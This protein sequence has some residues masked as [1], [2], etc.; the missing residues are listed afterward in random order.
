[1]DPSDDSSKR[2]P[3]SGMSDYGIELPDL[4]RNDLSD[5]SAVM[6]PTNA[7]DDESFRFDVAAGSSLRSD[8]NLNPDSPTNV[9]SQQNPGTSNGSWLTRFLRGEVGFSH[10]SKQNLS[11]D[12][13][14]SGGVSQAS[15][16]SRDNT[17]ATHTTVGSVSER[18]T[19]RSIFSGSSLRGV[20]GIS[21]I[22]RKN[23]QQQEEEE[24]EKRRESQKLDDLINQYQI[25]ESVGENRLTMNRD[26]FSTM[27]NL[28]RRRIHYQSL[29]ILS[30]VY[31]ALVMP[32][33]LAFPMAAESPGLANSLYAIDIIFIFEFF[34][35]ANE[36]R[37]LYITSS[38]NKSALELMGSWKVGLVSWGLICLF[39][40]FSFNLVCWVLGL[41][42]TA[43]KVL[44]TESHTHQAAEHSAKG[45]HMTFFSV[46]CWFILQSITRLYAVMRQSSQMIIG[47][48]G[49]GNKNQTII[50]KFIKVIVLMFISLHMIC[51]F[52]IFVVNRGC[53]HYFY[54]VNYTPDVA[55]IDDLGEE[56]WWKMHFD[57]DVL[58]PKELWSLYFNTLFTTTAMFVGGE[59]PE[60][61]NPFESCV[62]VLFVLF[63]IA[64]TAIFYGQ[65]MSLIHSL[66][67]KSLEYRSKM[68]DV[69]TTMEH[70]QLPRKL[71]ERVNR[72]FWYCWYRYSNF[73][74][75]G[76]ST[77]LSELSEP[78]AMEVQLVCHS[79]LI[80]NIPLFTGANTNVMRHV[81]MSIES[82]IFLP[83][84]YVFRA[85]DEASK[86]YMIQ[87]GSVD[88]LSG[89]EEVI[90]TLGDGSYFGEVALL[91]DVKRTASAKALQYVTCDTLDKH[92]FNEIRG[93]YSDFN[94]FIV[95]LCE[96]KNYM[97]DGKAQRRDYGQARRSVYPTFSENRPVLKKLDSEGKDRLENF[98]KKLESKIMEKSSPGDLVRSGSGGLGRRT[99]AVVGIGQRDKSRRPWSNGGGDDSS[100]DEIF[101]QNNPIVADQEKRHSLRSRVH[102]GLKH[103]ASFSSAPAV[104]RAAPSNLLQAAETRRIIREE[105]QRETDGLKNWFAKEL[106]SMVKAQAELSMKGA[107]KPTFFA[108]KIWVGG[109]EVSEDGRRGSGGSSDGGDRGSPGGGRGSGGGRIGG[110]GGG[111]GSP[112]SKGSPHGAAH[113]GGG[114]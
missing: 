28:A 50:I 74:N 11:R 1:M 113:G 108:K 84:D 20:S 53:A 92:H 48:E 72:Y 33:I 76:V 81:M 110:I 29:L 46:G 41:G 65:T 4:N 7:H 70:L 10:G 2:S 26:V 112:L 13:S 96:S 56:C 42:G 55:N 77:F 39:N 109:E 66:N 24:L 49:G 61:V 90:V 99:S 57:V 86:L 75:K 44:T 37:R 47:S 111:G 45:N 68:E 51:L 102:H 73:T 93:M 60:P 32:W 64:F 104:S 30:G 40:I 71:R 106:R 100:D 82:E 87:N 97:F 95:R 27:S 63:G 78:L 105:V 94:N 35:S 54:A 3:S 12:P 79:N 91:T 59:N 80:G 67:S 103:T 34:N 8:N 19:S 6:N 14:R 83:G 88:I 107:A 52:W 17:G 43:E 23:R 18:T 22:G 69:N 101:G 31:C 25:R 9:S 114:R 85:G 5:T 21:F 38:L 89:D 15:S 16:R 62:A 36:A 98:A 58:E